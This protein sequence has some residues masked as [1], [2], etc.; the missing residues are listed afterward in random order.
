MVT[1]EKV[2]VAD[3]LNFCN[4]H[5]PAGHSPQIIEFMESIPR[6]VLGKA[7]LEKIKN[8]T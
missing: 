2:E 6:N 7:D 4:Q 8:N 1:S 5:M 3:L